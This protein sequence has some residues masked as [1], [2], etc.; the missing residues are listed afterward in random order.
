MYFTTIEYFSESLFDYQYLTSATVRREQ[1][2]I[3][4]FNLR[5]SILDL[6][7]Q[8]YSKFLKVVF[9]IY[10][11]LG[12]SVKMSLRSK[13]YTR[14]SRKQRPVSAM[15]VH[16]L[17]NNI[18]SPYSIENNVRYYEDEASHYQSGLKFW[19]NGHDAVFKQGPNFC[20][21]FDPLFNNEL[22]II[23][24]SR[25]LEICSFRIK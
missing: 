1:K 23:L 2:K 13:R 18:T 9:L 15:S 10:L 17:E 7:F 14:A 20:T 11:R 21:K 6:D 8:I 12:E 22:H 5:T 16:L 3:T 24:E 19:I 25:N 4:F